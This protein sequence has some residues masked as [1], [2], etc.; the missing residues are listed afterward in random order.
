[1]RTGIII[2]ILPNL[3]K[4][5]LS[6]GIKLNLQYTNL[7]KTHKKEGQI[8]NL[9]KIKSKIKA[10]KFDFKRRERTIL[11]FRPPYIFLHNFSSVKISEK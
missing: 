5:L 6:A 11:K 7:P 2:Y 9:S 1:M 10:N 8:Q 3:C 4:W